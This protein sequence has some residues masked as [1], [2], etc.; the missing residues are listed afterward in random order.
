[1]QSDSFFGDIISFGFLNNEF[2]SLLSGSG[3]PIALIPGHGGN[4]N[5]DNSVNSSTVTSIN[6]TSPANLSSS[7]QTDS[8]SNSLNS[9]INSNFNNGNTITNP[10][11][12]RSRDILNTSN[13]FAT[14]P[15]SARSQNS[16]SGIPIS[17]FGENLSLSKNTFIDQQSIPT[18]LK[19][20][21]IY[22][23]TP[24]FYNHNMEM[25]THFNDK[26]IDNGNFRK[27]SH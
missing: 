17:R 23:S 11:N 26:Q 10:N 7:Q 3:Q 14:G 25:K 15:T 21:P 6:L 20:V 8:L 9:N 27:V 1:M 24:T 22:P 12:Y 16:G 5:G 18:A 13:G 4:F 19:F 2:E